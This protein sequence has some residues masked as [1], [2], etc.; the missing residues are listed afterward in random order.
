MGPLA[1]MKVVELAHMMAGPSCG[2]L[3][4]DMGAEVIKV[5]KAQGG[6]DTRRLVPPAV[7]GEPA[8]FMILNRGKRGVALDLKSEGGRQALLRL[9]ADADAVLENFRPGTMER[10]GLGYDTLKVL[11]PKLIYC[12]ITG[13][14][15]TGPYAG[16]AGLDLIAQGMSGLMS[17]TGEA[18][19]RAP[20]KAGFPVADI[21]AGLLAANGIL[22]AYARQLRTG[23]GQMVDTSL[24]EASIVHTYWASAIAFATGEASVPLGSAHHLAAPYQALPTSDGWVNVGCSTQALWLRLLGAID[25]PQLAANPDF[26]DNAARMGHLPALVEAL[27]AIFRQRTTAEWLQRLDA[28]GVPCGPV[29]D[30]N[31]MHRDPQVVARE[32]V[33]TVQH[34]R[35]GAVQAL[36]CPVKFSDSPIDIRDGAPILGQD[37]AQVLREHGYAEQ[38]IEALCERGEL[39]DAQGTQPSPAPRD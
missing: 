17:L 32:M 21:T 26:A 15:T 31:G 13:F 4:S 3:L 37:T 7:N 1:G 14:G 19:G 18:A 11:N 39:F 30:V 35:A 8:S 33:V 29:L 9:L 28:A 10:L 5:E 38:E 22:A 36:G 12:R 25:D 16:R 6:D 27:S 24:M 20:V 34:R 23:L 2:L